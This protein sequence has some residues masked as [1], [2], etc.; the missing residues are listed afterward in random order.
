M[1][2]EPAIAPGARRWIPARAGALVFA[3]AL[4]AG[5]VRGQGLEADGF[6]L[7]QY[8]DPPFETQMKS[9]L[10]GAKA[11]PQPGGLVLI[12]EAKLQT[13]QTNGAREMTVEA[14]LCMFDSGTRTVNSSGPVL[15]RSADGKLYLEGKGFLWQQTNTHL[16]IS[17]QS[18]TLI[19]GA[20]T[21]SF[22]R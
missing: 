20:L 15:V 8:Y 5:A 3:L 13:F 18:R 10:E 1:R 2:A 12:S 22:I 11:R 4:L 17:N 19:R 9:L 6:K 21:N 7:P 16:I 14:P